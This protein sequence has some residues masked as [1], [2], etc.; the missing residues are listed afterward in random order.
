MH[1]NEKLEKF[2]AFAEKVPGV[3][4][5]H[6]IDGFK[7]IFMTR[8]GLET[9]DLSKEELIALGA[10]YSKRFFNSEFMEDY[11]NK[12][13]SMIKEDEEH[14]IYT[15]FHQV[16]IPKK[17]QYEWYISSI[18]VFHCDENG[19]PSHT[20]TS[21]FRVQE[22]ERASKKAERLL[23]ES[24]FCKYN[25]DRFHSLS[26][27]AKEV[28]KLVALGKTSAEI[29]ED[30]N[31]SKDTVNTHRMNIKQKLQISSTYEFTE[32]ALCFDLI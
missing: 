21:A 15:F 23:E 11:L 24:L 22:F 16:Q 20:V 32:Y 28:L 12:L 3:T 13:R 29:A 1:F 18:K 14:E 31:I 9:L 26:H 5:I 8:N 17:K 10:S 6:E 30:L 19:N 4:V 7:P 2:A 27:R 25:E